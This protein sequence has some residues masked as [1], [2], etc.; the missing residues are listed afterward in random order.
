MKAKK[1]P[2]EKISAK[3]LGVDLTPRLETVKVTEPPKRVGGAK[4]GNVDELVAKMK[5]AGVA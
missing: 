1:K 5:A 2:I 3:D 4:V